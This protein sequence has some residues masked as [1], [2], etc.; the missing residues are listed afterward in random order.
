MGKKKEIQELKQSKDLFGVCPYVTSQSIIQGKWAILILHQLEGGP[1]R[2][3]EL[4]RRIEIAQGT[5]SKQLKS[6]ED[7]GMIYRNVQAEGVLKVE[8]ELT[9][10]GG[11]FKK[12]L[13]SI[14][15]WGKEYI[16]YLKGKNEETDTCIITY[17]RV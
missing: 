5:L 4:L 3:N 8:Y 14:E 1:L 13:N 9:E 2:F 6:L 11:K 7:E 10:I 17:K 16:E 15:E 12:V